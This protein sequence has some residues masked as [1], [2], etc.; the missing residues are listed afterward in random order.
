MSG[1]GI[2]WRRDEGRAIRPGESAPALAPGVALAPNQDNWW[3]HDTMAVS[4]SDVQVGAQSLC[5]SYA[6]CKLLA[7][8]KGAAST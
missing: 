1:D 7:L 6:C 4:V 2:T 3:W 5:D 8:C